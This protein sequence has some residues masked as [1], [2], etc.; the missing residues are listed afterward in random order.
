MGTEEEP[1]SQNYEWRSIDGRKCIVLSAVEEGDK[2]KKNKLKQEL[3]LLHDETLMIDTKS[4]IDGTEFC[5]AIFLT[6]RPDSWMNSFDNLYENMAKEESYIGGGFKR[7]YKN[8]SSTYISLSCYSSKKKIMAQPGQRSE[9]NLI[10]W[11]KDFNEVKTSMD[12]AA[13]QVLSSSADSDSDITSAQKGD[14]AIIS[15]DEISSTPKEKPDT[16]ELEDILADISDEG[17]AIR[18]EEEK[19]PSSESSKFDG[20]DVCVEKIMS[21]FRGLENTIIFS[22][23]NSH[24]EVLSL[25][26]KNYAKDTEEMKT[27]L[28]DKNAN[29]VKLQAKCQ[30][31]EVEYRKRNDEQCKQIN[32][33]I[34]HIKSLEKKL[35]KQEGQIRSWTE[36]SNQYEIRNLKSNND[37]LDKLSNKFYIEKEQMRKQHQEEIENLQTRITKSRNEEDELHLKVN[38]YFEEVLS[39]KATL[40]ALESGSN[41]SYA[42]V[43][44][45]PEPKKEAPIV[46]IPPVKFAGSDNP[47]S[48]LFPI[49]EGM[50]V[51]LSSILLVFYSVE[52]AFQY[53]KAVMA[54]NFEVA[55]LILKEK[56][57]FKAMQAGKKVHASKEWI[58]QEKTIMKD[59]CK[60]KFEKCP[61][62]HKA[63]VD[64]GNR[65]LVEDT[66]NPK[67]GRGTKDQPGLNWMGEILTGIRDQQP[68]SITGT[69]PKTRNDKPKPPSPNRGQHYKN[70]KQGHQFRGDTSVNRAPYWGGYEQGNYMNTAY[71]HRPWGHQ[72]GNNQRGRGFNYRQNERPF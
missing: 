64:S 31:N 67:W 68:A 13:D 62:F 21:A 7:T 8:K 27:M 41:Q 24:E 11:I 72:G 65:P 20:A 19:G 17:N 43:V 59:L 18:Q 34:E 40:G 45:K 49:K 5:D 26:R 12:Q 71:Q 46:E 10:N 2:K 60:L 23:K 51:R 22:V 28:S 6:Q 53:Q 54:Q 9:N 35:D 52:E 4:T 30:E 14:S 57:G 15:R 47:L 38:R 16:V 50:S 63:L 42:E 25:T 70:S 61:E 36:K 32:Q 56:D 69:I 44:K 33:L 58:G 3:G 48:N 37:E 39:L 66:P 1:L 55:E 29:I